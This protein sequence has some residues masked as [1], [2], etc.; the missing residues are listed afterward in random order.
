[1]LVELI[2]VRKKWPASGLMVLVFI[3]SS[4]KNELFTSE[5]ILNSFSWMC[6]LF[7][8]DAN[9]TWV[10]LLDKAYNVFCRDGSWCFLYRNSAQIK[11]SKP[12]TKSNIDGLEAFWFWSNVS[13]SNWV[14]SVYFMILV[15]I[16]QK[17]TL[18]QGSKYSGN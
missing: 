7:P 12:D 3:R 6:I 16:T 18:K 15:W 1:M 5:L 13:A 4:M 10:V 17:Q 8:G 11:S 2:V 14:V 9:L